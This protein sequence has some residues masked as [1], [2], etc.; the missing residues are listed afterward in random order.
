MPTPA[1][2]IEQLTQE[3]HAHNHAY[4]VEAAP[5]ISDREFDAL[6][7]ELIS[8]EQAYPELQR[9]DSPSQRVGGNPIDGFESRRHAVP[10][11][12]LANSYNLE[13]VE[14]WD[15]RTRKLLN[16]ASF[17]YSVEP[18]IDGIAVSLRYEKG[19][20]VYALT[21]GDGI[22]GDDVTHNVKT[23]RSIPLK[24]Q[25]DHP[26]E[27]LEVRGEIYMDRAG[28]VRLNAQREAEGLSTFANPRNACAGTMKMLDPRIVALRPLDA[29]LYATGELT[30]TSYET[31]TAMLE[32]LKT[33]GFRTPDRVWQTADPRELGSILEEILA[34][35][36]SYPYEMDGAV[37]KVNQRELYDQL[38]ST[39]K[40]PRWAMAYKYEPEQAETV[41]RDITIQ[42]GR[43][44]VLTPVAELEPVEV[45]GTTVSRATLHNWEEMTRKDIRVGDTVL[46]EKAGEIIPAV[47]RVIPEK[48]PLGA[49]LLAEPTICPACGEPVSRREGEVAWRCTN[50]RCPAQARSWILHFASRRCM[51]IEGLGESL[52]D[53]L[54][55]Q[56]LIE[57][58]ADLY[59]LHER[60]ASLLSLERMGEKS[61]A[62]LLQG[63]EESKQRE[64]WRLLHAMGIPHVG[65]RMAQT[66]A[67]E[68]GSIDA[69]M[70]ADH[71]RL[72][73]IHDVGDV[74]VEEIR[75]FF[76]RADTQDFLQRLS[77]AGVQMADP[78][79]H[80]QSSDEQVA[81]EF[82][83]KTVVLTG[84]LESMSRNEAGDKLRDLGANVTGSVS[85]KTD[86][87]IAGEKAG[88][89]LAKAEKLGIRVMT[90]TEMLRSLEPTRTEPKDEQGAFF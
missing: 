16:N 11:I 69:L 53:V 90:E 51:D 65:E 46:I 1:D 5:R 38:G 61:V 42:V 31:H 45:S 75:V 25:T 40:S 33:Y 30:G 70:R 60:R 73:S 88:S 77:S 29:V 10:M 68:F 28:F 67:Q 50:V 35:K 20:L 41:L 86:I 26:P 6:L 44:G 59:D 15:Q 71:E 83:G 4:Y 58:P 55:E 79:P 34:L 37:M 3:L 48:R 82:A 32:S 87:L 9:P 56:G 47:V 74:V 17:S 2:R 80:A 12:S 13:D 39:S 54:L 36:S 21:R 78:A 63:I 81:S 89:K 49:E 8:L 62:N 57:H 85:S 64:L 43:T 72:I 18:K 14:D 52:V 76:D 27:V 7:E 66:L 22:Q 23:I 24:L 84:S 19:V